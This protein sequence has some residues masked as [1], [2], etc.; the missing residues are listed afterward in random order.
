MD[1]IEDIQKIFT[2]L[3]H[4]Y[5]FL[6]V[7]RIFDLEIGKSIKALKN[8]TINEPFFQGHFP[9]QPVMPGV[10]IIEALAQ[11]GS[12]LAAKTWDLKEGKNVVYLASLDKVKFRKMVL[13]GDQL[14]LELNILKLKSKIIKMEGR[15]LVDNNIVAEAVLMASTGEI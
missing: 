2:L 9:G 1:K 15:A 14:F 4:R 13:P 7:D 12:I 3:Q 6:L 5:P 11:A 10:L 8:V